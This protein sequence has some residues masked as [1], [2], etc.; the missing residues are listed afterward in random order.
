[1][2]SGGETEGWRATL[3]ARAL[4]GL[5][6]PE[7]A[8]A[9]AEWAAHT[10]RRRGMHWQLPAA[11]LVLAEAR[12]AAGQPGVAEALDEATEIGKRRGHQVILQRI[13][14]DRAALGVA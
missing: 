3:R 4:L 10:A 14:T 1:M 8:L 7:E 5:E 13:A 11:L 9:Q 6:R 12:D 2:G